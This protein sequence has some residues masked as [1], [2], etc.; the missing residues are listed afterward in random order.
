MSR[1]IIVSGGR[2]FLDWAAVYRELVRYP[3]GTV[4]VHGACRRGHSHRH[5]ED[6][7]P[8]CPAWRSADRIADRLGRALGFEVISVQANW[9][10]HGNAAGPIRNTV[11]VKIH[12]DAERAIVFDGG[13]GTRDFTRKAI[14]AHIPVYGGGRTDRINLSL[15]L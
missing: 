14:A 10:E 6:C 11:M 2:D 9:G 1:K 15:P 7:P 3:E 13:P 12:A 4:L 5:G 8:D